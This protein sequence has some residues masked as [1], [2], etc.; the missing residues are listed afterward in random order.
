MNIVAVGSATSQV[1]HSALWIPKKRATTTPFS[2]QFQPVLAYF[3]PEPTGKIY[4]KGSS[5]PA[6]KS[7]YRIPCNSCLILCP[8]PFWKTKEYNPG[9]GFRA[10][11][12]SGFHWNRPLARGNLNLAWIYSYIHTLMGILAGTIAEAEGKESCYFRSETYRRD[13][14]WSRWIFFP[15]QFPLVSGGI[16]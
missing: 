5:I 9:Q 1:D 13:C 14:K 7:P 8:D 11:K 3:W 16:W 10:P 6:P 12:M 2:S 15:V 4:E